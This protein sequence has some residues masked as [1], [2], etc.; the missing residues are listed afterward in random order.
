M[1]KY[2]KINGGE[3]DSDSL[4]IDSK[5]TENNDKGTFGSI[6][7]YLRLKNEGTK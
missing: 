7:Q 3:F 6:F 5:F 1:Y 2:S 4:S